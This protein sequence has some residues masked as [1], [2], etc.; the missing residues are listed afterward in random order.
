MNSP[1]HRAKR[2]KTALLT[3]AVPLLAGC[4]CAC[5]RKTTDG[6]DPKVTTLG[7]IEATGRLVEIL[8][9]FPPND[10]YDYVYIL[11]YKVL[12]TH[13][14][15][16][17]GESILVGQ[18]NP[19]KPR[20]K[21]ADARAEGIG[22]DLKTFKAGDIHRMALDVPLDDHY[23]GPIINKYHGKTTGPLYW[24]IWTNRVIR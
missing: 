4:C 16:V 11:K 17:D 12:E 1:H 10:L 19:L 7:S 5:S 6:V 3:I 18:Y 2:R 9:T 8:G 13:R 14:G 21:A 20:A 15:K 22:G 23:M 24:A